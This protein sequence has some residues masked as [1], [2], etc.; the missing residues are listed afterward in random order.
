M[1]LYHGSYET[2]A[3]GIKIGILAFVSSDNI[4]DG[5]FASA[6]IQIAASH[7]SN[8][9]AYDVESI[10]DNADLNN[11]IDDVIAFLATEINGA[12]DHEIE[13]LAYALADDECNAN[14]SHLLTPR[15]CAEH[16]GVYSWEMQRLRGR[17]AAILGYDAVEM[18]DEHGNSYLIV[19][20]GI[21]G[22]K[23]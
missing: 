22:I 10:A 3:P 1:K 20:P 16:D 12:D 11:K 23:C 4:F 21:R 15:S 19:N 18:N 7:A 14:F 8:V 2:Q 6:D 17:I 9:Y 5:I 13:A